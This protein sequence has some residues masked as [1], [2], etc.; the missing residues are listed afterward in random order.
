M[1][2]SN[3]LYKIKYEL[4]HKERLSA[5]VIRDAEAAKYTMN[6]LI[7]GKTIQKDSYEIKLN[8]I[9]GDEAIVHSLSNQTPNLGINGFIHYLMNN[10]FGFLL[11]S[12]IQVS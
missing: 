5:E 1:T 2:N 8:D 4:I 11:I 10:P 3:V 6:F 12:E 9:E 7:G